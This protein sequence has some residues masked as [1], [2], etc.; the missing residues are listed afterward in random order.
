MPSTSSRLFDRCPVFATA[1]GKAQAV[2]ADSC[3]THR[4]MKP[5]YMN[6]KTFEYSSVIDSLLDDMQRNQALLGHSCSTSSHHPAQSL[7]TSTTT[8]HRGKTIG[9]RSCKPPV[10]NSL[11][12]WVFPPVSDAKRT[13]SRTAKMK[14]LIVYNSLHEHSEVLGDVNHLIASK[15]PT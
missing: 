10:T 1:F 6:E 15:Q 5:N 2:T 11:T 8:I 4:S 9:G 3:R 13:R 12:I 7:K 14:R